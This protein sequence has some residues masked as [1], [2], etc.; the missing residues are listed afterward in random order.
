VEPLSRE[1]AM[2]PRILD[3]EDADIISTDPELPAWLTRRHPLRFR[4]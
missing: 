4:K 3:K 2:K 1:E